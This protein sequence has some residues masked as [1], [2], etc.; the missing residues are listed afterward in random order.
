MAEELQRVDSNLKPSEL[1]AAFKR[2]RDIDALLDE[3]REL[4][5]K[6]VQLLILGSGCS[7]KTTFLKQLQILYGEGYTEKERRE[8]KP[9]IYGN[10]RR[11][12]IRILEAMEEIGLT[13]EIEELNTKDLHQELLEHADSEDSENNNFSL[14]DRVLLLTKFW[15]DSS[16]KTCFDQRNL[17][18]IDDSAKYFFENLERLSDPDYIPTHEDI[19]HARQQTHGVQERKISVNSYHYRKVRDIVTRGEEPP[20][21]PYPVNYPLERRRV[22]GPD[23][24]KGLNYIRELFLS[25][26]PADKDM[27]LHVTCATDTDLMKAV[28]K[29]VFEI[30]V[31]INLKKLSTL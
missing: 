20:I 6:E 4:K 5:E 25:K 21:P 28:L 1:K 30:L 16:V 14:T 27:Y 26:K 31:D 17:F 11:A 7:G 19:L 23:P 24:E 10:V 15:N 12:M 2:S 22:G 29:D 8:F 3:E 9:V 18:Y 13:F